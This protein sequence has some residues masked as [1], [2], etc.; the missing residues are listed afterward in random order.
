M[1]TEYTKGFR[2]GQEFQQQFLGQ[3]LESLAHSAKLL[4][5]KEERERII[6]LL[7]TELFITPTDGL[8]GDTWLPV[9]QLIALIKGEK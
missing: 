7:E 3:E 8:K 1:E 5:R 4:G 2:A 6:K 9:E